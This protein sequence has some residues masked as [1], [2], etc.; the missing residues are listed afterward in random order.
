MY[1][2][3]IV[4]DDVRQAEASAAAVL[5]Y[6]GADDLLSVCVLGS[7][8]EL[9]RH[10]QDGA[11]LDI[12][13]I[14]IVFDGEE[15]GIDAVRR[16]S[17]KRRNV[18]VI[19]T[20]GYIEYCT[21]VYQTSHVYFLGKP[22]AQSELDD[23][24]ACAIANLDEL[25]SRRPLV[26]KSFGKVTSVPVDTIE[27]IE[28]DRRKIRVYAEDRMVEAYASLAEVER[29]LPASFV[30][31]HKSFMVNMDFVVELSGNEAL[32]AS[33]MRV[34]VSQRHRREVHDRL[35]GYLMDKS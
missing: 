25:R 19:Y 17:E 10:V 13:L 1:D 11:P 7:L 12:L 34:P 2:V 4:D 15:A 21:R 26:L 22:L 5:R 28:S 31:C 6:P 27:R 3:I 30:R 32:M 9:D 18:Q 20:T 24:L 14:D 8:E 29:L 16:L 23:A 33:G 35:V